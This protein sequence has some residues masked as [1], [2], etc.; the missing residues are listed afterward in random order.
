MCVIVWTEGWGYRVPY[1]GRVYALR[2]E[3]S[4]RSDSGGVEPKGTRGESVQAT[5]KQQYNNH[6]N[7][8]ERSAA[9]DSVGYRAAISVAVWSQGREHE[10]EKVR[11]KARCNGRVRGHAASPTAQIGHTPLPYSAE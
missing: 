6:N 1:L 10:R 8:S 11:Q 5:N 7:P 4:T 9:E 3:I 2:H